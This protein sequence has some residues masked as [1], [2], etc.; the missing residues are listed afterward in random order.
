[1]DEKLFLRTLEAVY[2]L[3]SAPDDWTAVLTRLGEVFQANLSYL[4]ERDLRTMQVRASGVG[5]DPSIEREYGETWRYRNPLVNATRVWRSGEVV[6]DQM[7][8]PKE[9]F[10]R[11]P[12]YNEHFKRIGCHSIVRLSLQTENGIHQ[13][14][15]L[16][17]PLSA[18]EAEISEVEL[19]RRF[20]PHL[21]RVASVTQKLRG[22]T[23]TLDAATE[24][25]DINP[26]GVLLFEQTGRVAYANRAARQMASA[27]DG[28]VLRQSQLSAFNKQDDD[29]LQN[30]IAAATGRGR[31]PFAPRSGA[32]SI[33]R[34]SAA[35]DY[36]VTVAPLA[37]QSFANIAATPIAFALVADPSVPVS[38]SPHL[39]RKVF[40]LT[41]TEARL[42]GRL[43]E[44]DTTEQAAAAMD[45]TIATARGYLAALF[46]KTDTNRQSELVRILLS[47]PWSGMRNGE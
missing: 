38:P 1:V 30:L 3:A 18:G 9:E 22:S 29:A 28:L 24:L 26:T 35:R 41:A 37:H 20:I 25:L 45:I 27:S 32:V 7:I 44:G 21:R 39:L 4:H 23:A 34:K 12:Y 10:L 6:T 11:T 13:S 31:D 19:G 14:I 16:S 33:S 5:G 8:L 46:R 17:R 47:L 40:G 43:A 2:D 36:V 42:A 15:S